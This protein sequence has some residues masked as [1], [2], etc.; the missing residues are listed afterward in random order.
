L[1]ALAIDLGLL[2]LFAVQHSTM[3]RPAFKRAWTRIV[4]QPLERSFYVLATS[5]C[6]VVMFFFWQPLGGTV[7]QVENT[8][9]RAVLYTAFGFGWALVLVSTFLINHFDLFGLRQVWFVLIGREYTPV[10]F[11]EPMLYRIVRHPLYVGLIFA[12]WATPKMTAA[13][14]VLALVW[15]AY[16]VIAIQLEERDLVAEHGDSYLAYRERVP[17][18]VPGT[19]GRA[20]SA[21]PEIGGAA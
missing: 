21:A 16:I 8:V 13:H 15:T 18:L 12:F 3:A 10:R 7:W 9:A 6:L 14:L 19:R 4:P 1:P 20:R 2:L 11:V 17:M 5:L